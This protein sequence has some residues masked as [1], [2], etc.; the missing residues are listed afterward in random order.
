MTRLSKNPI[1]DF[2]KSVQAINYFANKTVTESRN[3]L[4]IVKLMWAAD[5]YHIRKY[6]RPVTGDTYFAM[7]NGPVASCVLNI[8]DKDKTDKILATP[9]N[10][11]YLSK[12]LNKVGNDKIESAKEVDIQQFSDT[13]IEA[14]EFALNNFGDINAIV[15]FTH[16]YPE[17][18]KH[19]GV[20]KSKKRASMNYMDFFEN[21]SKK[22][23]Q[24]DPFELDKE[25]IE[26]AKEDFQEYLSTYK[27]LYT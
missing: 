2:E 3:K 17:W 25:L 11:V 1:F 4:L 27:A 20:V 24:N 10:I 5:R 16:I 14:L 21:P 9:A 13:D 7:R 8:L 22:D 18:K 15:Q 19:E 23:I 26:F 12:Y 6:G